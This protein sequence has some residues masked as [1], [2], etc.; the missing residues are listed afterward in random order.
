MNI[1]NIID[2]V[3]NEIMLLNE[4]FMIEAEDKFNFWEE[5]IKYVVQEALDLAAKYNADLEIVELAAILH[6][7]ASIAKIGTRQDHH[8]NGAEITQNILSKYDYPQNKID[9]VKSCVFNHRSSK[10][11]IEIEDI[12]VADA[13]ILAHFDNIPMLLKLFFSNNSDNIALPE[14]RNRMKDF[15]DYDYNDL[16]E[17]TRQNFNA[18]YKLI[19][20]I[21]LGF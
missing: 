19:C 20:N 3:K 4:K 14:L 11:G 21:V 6:D 18:R 7:V 1:L 12:C 9:K 13:D 10:N 2:N 17:R 5:H 8:I 16:S 15:F